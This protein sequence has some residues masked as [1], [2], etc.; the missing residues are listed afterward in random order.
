MRMTA[1]DGR[2]ARAVRTREAIVDACIALVDEG[3]VRP[4]ALRVAERAGVSVRSVFQHFDD[5]E[6][7]YAAIANRLVDRLGGVKV[8]VD[9]TLPLPER[10]TSMVERRS[11]ALEILTPIR[12]AAAVHAPFSPEVR[13]RLQAGHA[14]L[15]AELERVFADELVERDEPARTQMLDA[16]DTVLSWP[17]WE[18]LRTLNGRTYEESR[19]VLEQMVAAMLL[20]SQFQP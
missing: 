5:L 7:L 15:R 2:T 14:M 4:T 18:N 19:A 9:A 1:I 8:I 13:T 20:P 16:L 6:G 17:S 10:I 11:R 12:R 3:D